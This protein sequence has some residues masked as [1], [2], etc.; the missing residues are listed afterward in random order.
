MALLYDLG[1]PGGC[2]LANGGHI[3]REFFDQVQRRTA[4]APHD[5]HPFLNSGHRTEGSYISEN[6]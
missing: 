4:L 3:L 1:P 2:L 5:T 6:I